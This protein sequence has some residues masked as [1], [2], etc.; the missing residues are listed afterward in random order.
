MLEFSIRPR[1]VISIFIGNKQT[2]FTLKKFSAMQLNIHN[3]Y[4]CGKWGIY[5]PLHICNTP[6]PSCIAIHFSCVYI[7]PVSHVSQVGVCMCGGQGM[8]VGHVC[9]HL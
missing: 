1:G 2:S 4:I 9:A 5:Q 8:G 6:I 3:Q 7:S